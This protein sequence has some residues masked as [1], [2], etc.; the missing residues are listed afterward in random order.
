MLRLAMALAF[1]LLPSLGFAQAPQL[2]DPGKLTWGVSVTFPPFEY[3]DNGKPVGFDVDL[4]DALTKQM[5]LQSNL[6]GI[7]FKGLIPALEGKRIDAI[8]S[9][10]YI[11]PQRLEVADMVPYLLVGNQIVVKKGNPKKIAGTVSLC[12]VNVAAPVATVFE[13]SAKAAGAAC[14]AAGKPDIS[15]LSLAG[16]TACALALTQ[17]RADAIIVST[18]TVA[19][20]MHETP[21]AYEPAGAPFNADTKVGIAVRKDNP[22]LT[23]DIQKALQTV[24]KNGT[25]DALLKKWAMPAGS[26]AF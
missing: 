12:G 16:T 3:M 13:A 14:K 19:A 18:P 23:A 2:T 6:M 9:G 11:N 5:G 25:Y 17:G 24:V 8:V 20:L 10:M 26:S 4:V 22:G 15:L 7:E 21:D 1:T